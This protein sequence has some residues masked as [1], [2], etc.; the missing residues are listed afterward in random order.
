MQDWGFLLPT[1]SAILTMLYPDRF[2]VY[3]IRACNELDRFHNLVGRPFNDR[4]WS[5]YQMFVEVVRATAPG[6]LS[7]RDADRFL[8]GRSFYRDNAALLGASV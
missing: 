5:G 1:A 8:W 7:L 3:D 6:G 2:T 4:T